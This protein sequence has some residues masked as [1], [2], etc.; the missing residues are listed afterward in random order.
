MKNMLL[1]GLLAAVLVALALAVI[2]CSSHGLGETGT[3]RAE[4]IS[5]QRRLESQMLIDD[6]D[7]WLQRDRTSR[8]SEWSVR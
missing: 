8:L 7:V 2:G 5:R 4:D 6:I 1:N 3:E